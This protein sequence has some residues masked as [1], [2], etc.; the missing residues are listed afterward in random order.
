MAAIE[1]RYA[2]ADVVQRL[3]AADLRG[4]HGSVFHPGNLFV[5]VVGDIEVDETLPK[6]EAAFDGWEARDRAPPPEAPTEIMKPGL[7]HIERDVPQ[8]MVRIGL[9]GPQRG[10]PDRLALTVM[11][12]IL[13]GGSFSARLMKW[14]RTEE[15]LSYGAYAG[16]EPRVDYPGDFIT[17]FQTKSA[18]TAVAIQIAFE[19][20]E[21]IRDEL[22]A[23]EELAG[24][25]AQVLSAL[26]Q[27]F[28][29]KENMA[30]I[31]VSDAMTGRDPSY[32]AGISAGIEAITADD[33]RRVAQKWI[34]PDDMSI[35]IVGNWD[36]IARGDVDG[37]AD[38]SS[39]F[40]G[41]VQHLPLR[42]PL[43]LEPIE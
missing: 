23:D 24:A 41:E 28:S 13:G 35:L 19:E 14:I 40:G 34:R 22:V 3:T 27:V 25:K 29:S 12:Q 26:P 36:D 32:Y 42:D 10:D 39:F 8:A 18:T 37:R 43:T 33:V 38:I 5:T 17:H 11:S 16:V 6:L 4:F 1:A 30:Q 15:G 20:F 21:R 9:R 7:Y 31:F 2:R